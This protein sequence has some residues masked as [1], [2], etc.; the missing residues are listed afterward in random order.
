M[1]WQDESGVQR[2]LRL[3]QERLTPL[4]EHLMPHLRLSQNHDPKPTQHQNLASFKCCHPPPPPPPP[5]HTHTGSPM[6]WQLESGV[7]H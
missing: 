4:Q 1:H 3:G 7:H 2:T 5:T 6:H